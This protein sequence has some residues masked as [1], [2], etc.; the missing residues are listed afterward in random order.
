MN[1]ILNEVE[2]NLANQSKKIHFRGTKLLAD[3]M[4]EMHAIQMQREQET[5]DNIKSKVAR[6]KANQRKFEPD[7]IAAKTHHEGNL[8]EQAIIECQD[9]VLIFLRIY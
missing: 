3:R 5:L 6:I 2:Q 7:N 8:N 4:H 9:Y 1:K